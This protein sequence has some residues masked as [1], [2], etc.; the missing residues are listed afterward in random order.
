VVGGNHVIAGPY[1][2]DPHG[3]GIRGNILLVKNSVYH[4]VKS[5]VSA[6]DNK[7]PDTFTYGF[8]GNGNGMILV[9]CENAFKIQVVLKKKV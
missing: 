2:Y 9:L 8:N 6:Y 3:Y 1:G 5:P 4:F 7:M